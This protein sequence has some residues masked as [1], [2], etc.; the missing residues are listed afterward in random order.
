M[1]PD[2]FF[3][4]KGLFYNGPSSWGNIFFNKILA[5]KVGWSVKRTEIVFVVI[6]LYL[7]KTPSSDSPGSNPS[8]C[9]CDGRPRTRDG[10]CCKNPP[11][12]TSCWLEDDTETYNIKICLTRTSILLSIKFHKWTDFGKNRKFKIT[13]DFENNLWFTYDLQHTWSRYVI[14]HLVPSPKTVR[15]IL[16]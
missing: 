6:L 10:G 5:I 15:V 7:F 16:I 11:S 13:R 12:N 2:T 9:M 4:Q 14:S 1:V 3:V 8:S